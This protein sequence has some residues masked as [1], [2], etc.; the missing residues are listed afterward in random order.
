MAYPTFKEILISYANSRGGGL[1]L[2]AEEICNATVL[3]VQE[4]FDKLSVRLTQDIVTSSISAAT[5]V[6]EGTAERIAREVAREETKRAVLYDD[7][8]EGS[9]TVIVDINENNTAL[10]VHLDAQVVADISKGIKT[11]MSPPSEPS[12][13]VV[14]ENNAVSYEPL[15]QLGGGTKLYKHRITRGVMY[16]V[17]TYDTPFENLA[18]LYN[19]VPNDYANVVREGFVAM[20]TNMYCGGGVE[21]NGGQPDDPTEIRYYNATID[22]YDF[23]DEVTE[24]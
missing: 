7:I 15:S 12:V 24:L 3:W 9:D 18:G 19:C 5:E 14:G 17:T 10:E 6:A 21:L 1:P 2:S 11:P 8:I 4:E 20:Y 22:K 23:S 13:P 16:V